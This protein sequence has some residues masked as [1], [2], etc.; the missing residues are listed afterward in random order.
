MSRKLYFGTQTPLAARSKSAVHKRTPAA[1]DRLAAFW[2]Q[3]DE[4]YQWCQ[5]GRV[6]A[7]IEED[8]DVAERLERWADRGW[9]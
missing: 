2:L 9:R 4:P 1:Y 7:M 5:D 8:F 6:P 3:Q